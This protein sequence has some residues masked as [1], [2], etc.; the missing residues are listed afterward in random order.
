MAEE[1]LL[2][3]AREIVLKFANEHSED[4]DVYGVIALDEI[5]VIHISNIQS[6]WVIILDTSFP[7]KHM[8][9]VTYNKHKK[10]TTLRV[11]TTNND[12][13]LVPQN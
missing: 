1:D 3:K 2:L 6:S 7:A 8:Y 12:D 9:K 11:Y 10:E 5:H 4:N 13:T